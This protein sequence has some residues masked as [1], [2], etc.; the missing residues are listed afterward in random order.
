METNIYLSN[1][2]FAYVALQTVGLDL[3]FLWSVRA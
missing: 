3:I 1:S 2:E